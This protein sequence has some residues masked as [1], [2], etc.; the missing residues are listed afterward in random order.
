[1]CPRQG[2]LNVEVFVHFFP[3]SFAPPTPTPAPP[4]PVAA[5]MKWQ[6]PS[7]HLAILLG[8]DGMLHDQGGGRESVCVRQIERE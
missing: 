4:L 3:F 5:C 2:A 6:I 8:S 7:V 1:M